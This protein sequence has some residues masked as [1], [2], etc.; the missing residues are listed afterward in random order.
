MLSSAELRPALRD[1]GTLTRDP[2][3]KERKRHGN[4]RA[5]RG[6]QLQMLIREK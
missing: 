4:K 2:R 1:L 5:R 6:F 3:V